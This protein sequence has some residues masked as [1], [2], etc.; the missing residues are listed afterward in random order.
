MIWTA[1]LY[2]YKFSIGESEIKHWI[3]LNWIIR[4]NETHDIYNKHILCLCLWFVAHGLRKNVV[5]WPMLYNLATWSRLG[6]LR[7]EEGPVCT[8]ALNPD[9]IGTQ[10]II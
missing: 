1:V 5:W 2:L 3:E 6:P 7:L 10:I 9:G 8:G 4:W